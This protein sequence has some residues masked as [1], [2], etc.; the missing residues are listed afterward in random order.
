MC[1]CCLLWL[2]D[3]KVIF[4]NGSTT[5]HQQDVSSSFMVDVKET[6]TDLTAERAVRIPV[7]VVS[8]I[9]VGYICCH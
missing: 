8:Y 7:Y 5:Q 9:I 6:Q 4:Q 1:A 3:V 2:V